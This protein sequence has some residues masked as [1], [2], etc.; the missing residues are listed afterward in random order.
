MSVQ[1]LMS[2]RPAIQC[3][4]NVIILSPARELSGVPDGR[5]GVLPTIKQ[6]LGTAISPI[7]EDRVVVFPTS[8]PP[9]L[10]LQRSI[11]RTSRVTPFTSPL[12]PSQS[13]YT[14]GVFT[15]GQRAPLGTQASFPPGR[16]TRQVCATNWQLTSSHSVSL[17]F[18]EPP[19]PR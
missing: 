16:P 17:T 15:P 1:Y 7:P 14:P 10:A 18:G 4:L 3:S 8:Q 12:P 9:P 19:V 5:G 13:Y 2:S 11:S 6:P